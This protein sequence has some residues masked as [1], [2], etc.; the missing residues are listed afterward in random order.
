MRLMLEDYGESEELNNF[1]KMLQNRFNPYYVVTLKLDNKTQNTY[2]AYEDAAR[3]YH[4]K[5]QDEINNDR[6]YFDGADLTLTKV[7]LEYDE[8]ELE[9]DIYFNDEEDEYDIDA[10][11]EFNND[12]DD[13]GD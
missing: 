4:K 6:E 8:D 10:D 2:F 12:E 11:F 13:L 1:I 9:S 3:D 5:I 7:T